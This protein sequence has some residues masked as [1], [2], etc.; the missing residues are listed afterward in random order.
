MTKFERLDLLTKA[1]QRIRDRGDYVETRG[2][3]VSRS[4]IKATREEYE[5]L[6]NEITDYH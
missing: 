4:T 5:Y 6:L 3:K 2:G 1:T